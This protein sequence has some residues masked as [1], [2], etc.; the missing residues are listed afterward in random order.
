MLESAAAVETQEWFTAIWI[1]CMIIL[2]PTPSKW[3]FRGHKRE[4]RSSAE[5]WGLNLNYCRS[6]CK[7]CKNPVIKTFSSPS[8]LLAR[9]FRFINLSTKISSPLSSRFQVSSLSSMCAHKSTLINVISVFLTCFLCSES[10]SFSFAINCES[11]D[12][13]QRET[14]HISWEFFRMI[15]WSCG[16]FW[17]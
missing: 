6:L 11:F 2:F 4:I 8:Q 13:F 5:K 3:W 14:F 17:R 16:K 7:K 10:Q 12:Q 9:F 15:F 1:L